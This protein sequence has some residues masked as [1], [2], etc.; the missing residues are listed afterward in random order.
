MA[1]GSTLMASARINSMESTFFMSESSF[2]ILYLTRD[3][4][5]RTAFSR[6][7][8]GVIPL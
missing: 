6:K 1:R 4:R 3:E 2:L 5:Q 7:D 8:I